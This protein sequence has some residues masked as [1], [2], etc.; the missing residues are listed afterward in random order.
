MLKL[1]EKFL[2]EMQRILQDEYADFLQALQQK[3]RR[4]IRF[5]PLRLKDFAL[6]SSDFAKL[7]A[8]PWSEYGYYIADDFDASS[9]PYYAAGLYYLQEASAMAPVNN[10]PLKKGMKVLDLCSAP[11][12]KTLQIAS[13]I[14]EDGFLLSN[15]ISVSRQRATLRNIEKFG[16]K[17][18]LVSA[19]NPEKIAKNYHNYFDAIL[20]DAPCSGEGMFAKDKRTLD[21]WSA[22]SN[23]IYSAK[24]LEILQTIKPAL[25][26]GGF[27]M[28]STCTFSDKENEAVIN[29]FLESDYLFKIKAIE[30]DLL[31]DALA[32]LQG[33]KRIMPH[34]QAGLGH[35]MA[36]MQYVEHSCHIYCEDDLQDAKQVKD[37]KDLAKAK[38]IFFDFASELGIDLV[39]VLGERDYQNSKRYKLYSDKLYFITNLKLPEKSFRILRNG[40]LLGELK[41]DKF[42]PSQAL[43]MVIPYTDIANKIN[44]KSDDNNIK[45]YLRGE[46]L[47]I[48]ADKGYIL[49]YVD[50]LPLGWVL[51]DG[52]KLKNK[53][54]RDW[55]I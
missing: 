31:S 52:K 8:V 44:L 21:S 13:I 15:D 36:L 10:M 6:A 9:H 35:F 22:D 17:N 46:G 4:S 45:K 16:L 37:A 50:N 2:N 34:K 14:G 49:L 51:S 1:K 42:I 20:V 29:K 27:I 24:Q 12:G 33:A 32:S 53:L 48:V 11:G 3:P 41:H 7:E 23:E 39:S 38:S 19:E 30:N 28:Y 25:K 18:V 40:L 55:I 26:Q 5:N 43:A 54:K 47:A